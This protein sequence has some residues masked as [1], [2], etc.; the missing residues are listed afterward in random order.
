MD[1]NLDFDSYSLNL[2]GSGLIQVK[3]CRNDIS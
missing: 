1:E 3:A 2:L